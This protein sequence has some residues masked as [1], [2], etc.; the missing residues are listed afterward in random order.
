MRIQGD[1][2]QLYPVFAG[3]EFPVFCEWPAQGDAAVT[4]EALASQYT[5]RPNVKP[6]DLASFRGSGIEEI[7]L[8]AA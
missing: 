1:I 8:L 4:A 3:P 2:G 7:R 5:R 6:G